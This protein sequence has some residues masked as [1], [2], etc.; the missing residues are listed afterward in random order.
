MRRSPRKF[1]TTKLYDKQN[2]ATTTDINKNENTD[3]FNFVVGTTTVI[4]THLR[5]IIRIESIFFLSITNNPK[6]YTVDNLLH[7]N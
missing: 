2:V 1:E 3:I 5:K 7:N 6:T 4:N